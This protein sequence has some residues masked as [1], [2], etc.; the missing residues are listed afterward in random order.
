MVFIGRL[1]TNN[2]KLPALT[3][4]QLYRARWQ[5]KLF[6]KWIK[7]HV[8][9]K[10]FFGTS[11]NAVRAQIW[12]AITVYVLVTIVRKQLGLS[13]NVYQIL[14]VSR[15]S[16]ACPFYRHFSLKIVRNKSK[17]IFNQLN[18]WD[19]WPDSS[20][21]NSPMRCAEAVASTSCVAIASTWTRHLP[22]NVR[23]EFSAELRSTGVSGRRVC[24]G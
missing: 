15:F 8:R 19:L 11:E 21:L 7:Q 9:I 12:I 23:R 5:V 16:S 24:F 13:A 10:A 3:I 2:F 4:A 18:L 22:T 17:L 1:L 20:E 6:F 14:Q